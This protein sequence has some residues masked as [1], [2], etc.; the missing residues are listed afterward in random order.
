MN[1]IIIEMV[2]ISICVIAFG[3][4]VI[5]LIQI[6]REITSINQKLSEK[7]VNDEIDELKKRIEKIE[8]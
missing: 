2:L 6:K 1:P 8:N 4:I 3:A 5:T 7:K